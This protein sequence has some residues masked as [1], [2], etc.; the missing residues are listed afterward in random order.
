MTEMW[1]TLSFDGDYEVSDRGRVRRGD[2]LLPFTLS[3]VSP[4]GKRYL[5]DLIKSKYYKV[6][7]LVAEHWVDNPDGHSDLRFK[8][9]VSVSADNLEWVSRGRSIRGGKAIS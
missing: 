4:S 1:K 2:K 5:M 6:H 9:G 3:S 7:R 8:S